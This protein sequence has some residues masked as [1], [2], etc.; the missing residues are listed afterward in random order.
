MAAT[1]NAALTDSPLRDQPSLMS[2]GKVREIHTIDD[3]NA[4]LLFVATDR[5]SAYDVVMRNAVPN[6]GAVLT[7]LSKFWFDLL[8]AEIPELRT[9]FIALGVPESVRAR[10]APEQ[11]RQLQYRSMVVKRLKVFP[12]E[13]IVRGYI[14]GSAWSSYK[15]D[16]TVNG[17]Q[18]A[19]GLQESEKFPEPL[20]TPSTK[21]EL[22]GKDENISAEEGAFAGVC[23]D[24]AF[25]DE[26]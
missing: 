17:V 2:V 20:W 16:G 10:I 25:A 14:T 5:I 23:A 12:I 21:A 9:H 6:K 4:S 1:T 3:D 7:L 19:P 11:V 15:K 26:R 24:C 18:V 22:G 13:S 8:R